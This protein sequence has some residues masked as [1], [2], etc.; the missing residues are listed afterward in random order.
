MKPTLT[1]EDV[2]MQL[3]TGFW[4][5]Q[6]L[7]VAARLRLF[8]LLEKEPKGAEEL[9]R[10]TDCHGPSLVRL[11]RGCCSLGLM[12]ELPG[13][14]FGLTAL[15]HPL[16]SDHPR[17]MRDAII[18]MTDPG[19]WNSWTQLEHTVRSG[20][21]AYRRALGVENVFDYF[22]AH[23]EEST[24]FNLAM[25][26]LTRAFVEQMK[27]AYP[28]NQYK[29][30]ADIGGGRG[31]FLGAL[32]ADAPQ[33]RGILYD[34]PDVIREADAELARLG[35]LERVEKRSGS[36]FESAPEGADLYLLKHILHDWTDEQCATILAKVVQAMSSGAKLL[37]AEVLLPE[38]AQDS[39]AAMM[40]LNMMVMTGGC[41]RSEEHYV[42]LLEQAGLRHVRTIRLSSPCQL[43]EA[44][45][46]D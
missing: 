45:R 26:S 32:L 24:R 30:V 17:S 29:V 21:P 37:I 19:H 25:A 12:E 14:L 36:F 40:D 44:V 20:E 10:V 16:T 35:V 15:G 13:S 33:V 34:L 3:G 43:V 18:M 2:L 9:A 28:V 38:K 1:P 8:D 11:L 5:S 46:P 39:P 22:H 4:A 31:Q 6:V 42:R 27:A 23:P 41:E 7:S